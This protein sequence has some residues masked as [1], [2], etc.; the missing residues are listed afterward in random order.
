MILGALEG[1]VSWEK[2]AWGVRR[3]SGLLRLLWSPSRPLLYGAAARVG[4]C[5]KLV[6]V[7]Q[8]DTESPRSPDL[9]SPGSGSGVLRRI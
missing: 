8:H 2:T 3:R 1:M 9:P 6:D 4:S 7:G 5:S